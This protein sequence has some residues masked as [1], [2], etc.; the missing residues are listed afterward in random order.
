MVDDVPIMFFSRRIGLNGGYQVPI[1]AGGRVTGKAGPYSIG[2]LDIRTAS[3]TAPDVRATNFGVVRVKRDILRRSAIGAIV[4]DRSVSSDG[5]GRSRTYGVDGVFSF[6]QDL[7]INT[8]LARTDTGN[9]APGSSYRAQLDYNADRYGLQL[10]RLAVDERFNPDVGFMRRSAFHRSSAYARFSP[11]PQSIAAV[12]KFMWDVS[13]DYITNP[14]GRLESRQLQGS[15][16]AEL[17]NGDVV[18]AEVADNYESL[19]EPFGLS[20]SVTIPVGRY[21]FPEVRLLYGFGPQRKM[22]GIATIEHGGFYDGTRTSVSTNRGRIEV[23]PQISVEPGVAVNWIDLPDRRFAA[24]LTTTRTTYTVTPRMSAGA[25]I[26]YNSSASTFTSNVRLRW[27]YRPG[28]DL[29]V[30]YT[31]SRDTTGSGFPLIRN[32]GLVVKL[33]RLFR[34]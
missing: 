21:R 11:R 31:D 1:D 24:V 3:R 20:E 6:Y 5:L 9:D 19:E 17:Q 13:Y 34:M 28:S 16:R 14:A 12:R 29:F 8:Y 7:N 27:E 23:T 15:F 2:L 30:V 25:L 10:E 4:T 26:Q 33:T 22:S 18:G 32:R